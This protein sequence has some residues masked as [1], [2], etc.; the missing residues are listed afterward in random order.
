[1]PQIANQGADLFHHQPASVSSFNRKACSSQGHRGLHAQ[2][3]PKVPSPL[4]KVTTSGCKVPAQSKDAV[5]GLA[6]ITAHTAAL[7]GTRPRSATHYNIPTL[8]QRASLRAAQAAAAASLAGSAAITAP[9]PVAASFSYEPAAS[10]TATTRPAAA[11]GTCNSTGAV[12]GS[13][14]T[15]ASKVCGCQL[16]RNSNKGS[17]FQ[18]LQLVLAGAL[19]TSALAGLQHAAQSWLHGRLGCYTVRHSAAELAVV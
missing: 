8:Q 12:A 13:N 6:G 17:G 4:S 3:S 14:P 15:Q 9:D 19:L 7:A 10:A 2:Q 16:Q 18:Q 11:A 5:A 1:M